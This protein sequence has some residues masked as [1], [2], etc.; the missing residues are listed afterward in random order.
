MEAAF[1]IYNRAILNV[2]FGLLTLIF[3]TAPALC[4]AS[5]KPRYLGI[6]SIESIEGIE[7]IEGISA[8]MGEDEPRVLNI[9][10]WRAPT[11]PR[12][13]RAELEN[14]APELVQPLDPLVLER[15][16]EFRQNLGIANPAVRAGEWQ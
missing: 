15:H 10:P 2:S 13:P 5:D 12:R 3:V 7:G 9:L 4:A 6:E 1:W 11:L 8:S 16:R 14:T